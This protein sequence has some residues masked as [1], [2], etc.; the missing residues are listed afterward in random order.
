MYQ[1]LWSANYI[2]ENSTFKNVIQIS[3][4]LL[5]FCCKSYT[6]L[7][8]CEETYFDYSDVDYN[9][10][11]T[12]PISVLYQIRSFDFAEF[13]PPPPPTVSILVNFSTFQM[14]TWYI[15]TLRIVYYSSPLIRGKVSFHF[16]FI[17]LNSVSL[18]NSSTVFTK[19]LPR[20]HYVCY[21]I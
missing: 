17:C 6:P 3:L 7:S 19:L 16:Y 13:D 11:D 5:F 4:L 14:K 9:Y 10:D 21:N 1:V 12:Y 20:T 2:L 18:F 15:F 8:I